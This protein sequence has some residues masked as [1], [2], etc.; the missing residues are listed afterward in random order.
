MLPQN[1]L[2]DPSLYGRVSNF[3]KWF[4]KSVHSKHLAK[5]FYNLEHIKSNKGSF[6]AKN[7][8]SQVVILYQKFLVWICISS[9]F[10]LRADAKLEGNE[11]SSRDNVKSKF[12]TSE[13][14]KMSYL[15]LRTPDILPYFRKK[16]S[17]TKRILRF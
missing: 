8:Y 1:S 12:R 13:V 16:Y 3:L 14:V 17:K 7:E 10:V 9:C 2:K 11:T 5:S 6:Y 4:V 15:G